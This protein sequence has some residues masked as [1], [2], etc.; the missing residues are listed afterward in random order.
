MRGL[1]N[2]KLDGK[3]RY[4]L[5]PMDV[6]DDIV[7]ILTYGADKYA[8]NNWQGVS[9]ERY[10]A[11]S[12]RHLSAWKQG[13]VNDK[14]SGLPHLSH[15]LTNLVFMRWQERQSLSIE[16]NKE[17]VMWPTGESFTMDSLNSKIYFRSDGTF[18]ITTPINEE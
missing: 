8:P 15:A 12:M 14:E 3:R 11:A 16:K 6:M 4:E 17:G 9:S 18:D 1:K 13:E 2:D 7:D 10:F 5:L